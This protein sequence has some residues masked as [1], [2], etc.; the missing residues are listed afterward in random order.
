M[1]SIRKRGNSYNIRVTF[2]DESGK[3]IEISETYKPTSKK[4][5]AINKEVADRAVIFE[6]EVKNG[7]HRPKDK[8]KFTDLVSEWKTEWA[9]SHIGEPQIEQ[10]EGFLQRHVYSSIGNMKISQIKAVHLQKIINDLGRKGFAGTTIRR[11]FTA[12]NSVFKYA[13]RLNIIQENPCDRCELPRIEKEETLH[14]FTKEQAEVFLHALSE[15][16][17]FDHKK[18]NRKT[19]NN[20]EY[21]VSK[22]KVM[23]TIPL[24]FQAYFYM[25]VYG[26]FRRSELV[27]LTWND[28]DFETCTVSI[29]KS[30]TVSKTR[31]Q[32][33]KTP[34][35]P[36]GKREVVLPQK[37]FDLLWNWLEQQKKYSTLSTWEG[38]RGENILFNNVFVQKN[39]KCMDRSTP[40]HR[41][42]Q[43]LVMHNKKVEQE[44]AL[45]NSEVEKK[46]K[47]AELLP[48]IRLHDLRHTSA[49]LLISEGMDIE[50]VSKRIGHSRASVTM[51]IYGHALKQND[52]RAS[53]ILEN[54]LQ[55]KPKADDVQ[56]Q[57]SLMN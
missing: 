3:R 52:V 16:Y 44:I 53:S 15:S 49:T 50:T 9:V 40:S 34:K 57:N 25:A 26:G 55:T 22:Y 7:L 33:S 32:Y 10:Y 43:I 28:I 38:Y 37:C 12:I 13:Y 19:R 30:V 47:E 14:Y 46:K 5:T 11:I 35:T 48:Y 27:A 6:N 20:T 51:D 45:L 1:P 21:P 8:M 39:G 42:H 24:Q 31:G 36:S 56:A 29:T 18:S 41:F 2:I 17:Y 23:H 4:Q 54:I